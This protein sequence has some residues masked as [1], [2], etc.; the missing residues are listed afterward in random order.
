VKKQLAVLVVGF[1][2]VLVLAGQLARAA[3]G[4]G[5]AD[6]QDN[7]P[8]WSSDG[9]HV[10]YERSIG[11]PNRVLVSTSAGKGAH[12]VAGGV[13]RGWVPRSDHLLIQVSG[14]QTLVTQDSTTDRS[15]AIL[16]ATE[17]T[18]SPDGSKLAY[19]RDGTLYVAALN[20]SGERAI[21][22]DVTPPSWDITGPVWSPDGSRIVIAGGSS[23]L[24]VQADGSGKRTL[25]AGENQSVNP[26]WAPD[27]NTIAFE[28]NA[29]PH[30][31]IWTVKPDGSEAHG[32]IL[33]AANFR[34][35]R[36]SPVSN[37]LAYISDRQHA[38]GG[39]TQYQY[40][41][42]VLTP[43]S[44]AH[45][46]V[47]DVHPY[48]PPSWSPTAALI[49]VSAGQEC[50]R[51]GIYVGRSS[52]GSG[53]HRRSNLCRLDG[54]AAAD[55]IRGSEYFDIVNGNGGNDTIHGNGGN[56]K[57][58]GE[59]GNDTIYGDAGN[60]FVLA[61]P[62]NDRVFGGTGNDTIIGGNGH[63]RIDCGA[64]NDTV[65]GAGPL[66]VIARNC[67]HVRH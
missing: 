21:A 62:G 41:L 23:L 5:P 33:G 45:K 28:R 63:D 46:L 66:D 8:A 65:E 53:F 57:I 61:G 42:Y 67:E 11:P 10:A 54:T 17:A 55:T 16:D 60:D 29:G 48:S 6:P 4:P 64:G 24:L 20:G 7:L 30:W 15:I 50:R 58:S 43:G 31:E 59:D 52:V 9:V 40:A 27:G 13:L 37:T 34:Y 25:F 32:L 51:W 1:V 44:G 19:L 14:T 22:A 12:I 49:A 35:P 39:A 3:A 36:F 56:D 18:A 38:R 2:A 26:T 47:D